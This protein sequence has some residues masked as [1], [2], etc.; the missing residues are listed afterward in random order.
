MKQVLT[1]EQARRV[2]VALTLEQGG[3]AAMMTGKVSDQVD[4]WYAEGLS[5]C[6][7][8][9]SELFARIKL[10]GIVKACRR[11]LDKSKGKA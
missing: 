11:E 5:V 2:A 10:A 4:K 3:L 9:E 1:V 7:D 8:T 6:I